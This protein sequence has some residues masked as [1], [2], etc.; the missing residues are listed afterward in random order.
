MSELYVD[1]RK[2]YKFDRVCATQIEIKDDKVSGK[3]AG[4]V[5]KNVLIRSGLARACRQILK[6]SIRIG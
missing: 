2:V 1:L 5:C 6:N 4:T 3:L